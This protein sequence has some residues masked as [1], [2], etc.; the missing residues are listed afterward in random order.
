M[1]GEKERKGEGVREVKGK[2]GEDTRKARCQQR[3][4]GKK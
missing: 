2:E 3:K 4:E 1:E